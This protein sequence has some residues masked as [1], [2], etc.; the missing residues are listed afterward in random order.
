MNRERGGLTGGITVGI[1][2]IANRAVNL[3]N[4]D[5]LASK[6]GVKFDESRNAILDGN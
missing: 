3:W 1:I 2:G 6:L 5:L 4:A